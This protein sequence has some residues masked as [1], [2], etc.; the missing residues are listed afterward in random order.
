MPPIGW[1]VCFQDGT[2]AIL[3]FGSRI[4]AGNGV[5]LNG[6]AHLTVIVFLPDTCRSTNVGVENDVEMCE[7]PGLVAREGQYGEVM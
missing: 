6:I 4:S 5:G 1:T 2:A 7:G 3:V